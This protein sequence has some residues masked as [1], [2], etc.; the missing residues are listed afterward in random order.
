MAVLIWITGIFLIPLIPTTAAT[1]VGAGIIFISARFRR[2]NAVSTV[3]TV[4]LTM[5]VLIAFFW[6]YSCDSRGR[7]YTRTDWDDR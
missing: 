7:I 2:A 6:K 4:L 1:L 5:S 3:L